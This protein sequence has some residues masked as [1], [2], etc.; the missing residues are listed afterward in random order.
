MI[1]IATPVNTV[2]DVGRTSLGSNLPVDVATRQEEWSL[3]HR[4][5]AQHRQEEWLLTSTRAYN[6][7]Q[8]KHSALS[9][10]GSSAAKG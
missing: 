7:N 9:F 1:D 4:Y 5:I 6:T 2:H 8:Y 10:G 3:Q